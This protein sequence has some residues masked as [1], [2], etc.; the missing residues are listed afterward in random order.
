MIID[1][2][3]QVISVV[4]VCYTELI[5]T[6]FSYQRK[7][8]GEICIK[9]CCI[10]TSMHVHCCRGHCLLVS[11]CCTHL[12]YSVDLASSNFHVFQS[13]EYSFSGQTF[14]SDENVICAK[15]TGLNRWMKYSLWTLLKHLNVAGKSVLHLTE[16]LLINST[17][18][19]IAVCYF[20]VFCS[21]LIIH[22]SYYLCLSKFLCFVLYKRIV[23]N[24]VIF[25]LV[26]SS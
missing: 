23:V 3:E 7:N 1:Y 10:I 25:R 17:A 5:K 9:M 11:L 21:L 2:L 19:L 13:L 24:F 26:D 16:S 6:L 22:P 12:P 15:K 20:C 14:E 18:I 4:G 8:A